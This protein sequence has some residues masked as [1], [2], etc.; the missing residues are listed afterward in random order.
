MLIRKIAVYG[1]NF[2]L[3][4]GDKWFIF[5]TSVF[6]ISVKFLTLALNV[7]LAI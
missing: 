4:I 1:S 6:K 2:K 7:F 3:N 5:R